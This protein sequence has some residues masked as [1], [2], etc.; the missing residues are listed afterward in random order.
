MVSETDMARVGQ[1]A[2]TLLYSSMFLDF[3]D[4]W[5]FFQKIK[6][7]GV[8]RE[9]SQRPLV[10]A[11]V[12]GARTARMGD[13]RTC[14]QSFSKLHGAHASAK[15]QVRVMRRTSERA[16]RPGSHCTC[17]GARARTDVT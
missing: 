4:V 15:N 7:E 1:E 16:R 3:L 6:L 8:R 10:R 11:R 5:S 13:A 12:P 17:D 14:T 2:F 9:H